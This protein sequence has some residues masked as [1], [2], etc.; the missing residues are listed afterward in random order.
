LGRNSAI[1]VVDYFFTLVTHRYM[2]SLAIPSLSTTVH[3]FSF[4]P[5]H[6]HIPSCCYSIDIFLTAIMNHSFFSV[7]FIFEFVIITRC[8]GWTFRNMHNSRPNHT[9]PFSPLPSHKMNWYYFKTIRDLVNL[10]Q[11][12]Y[13]ESGRVCKETR[14]ESV[15]V[16]M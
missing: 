16:Q 4:F 3:L 6:T 13:I 2:P 7:C 10:A 8:L 11:K 15:N 9:I 1:V 14:R 12:H 5:P